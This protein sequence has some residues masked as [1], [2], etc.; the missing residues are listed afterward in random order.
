MKNLL[1]A[2]LLVLSGAACSRVPAGHVGVIVHTMGSSKGVDSEVV[3]IGYY[4][5]AP[6][7]N[8]YLFP[9]FMQNT[10]WTKSSTE[11]NSSN[12]ESFT[13]QTK[14][15]LDVNA[16]IGISYEIDPTKVSIIFQKYRSG[17]E[18]ITHTFLRNMIRDA[19]NKVASNMSVEE[20]YGSGKTKLINDVQTMVDNETTKL[21]I[22]I[23]KLYLTGSMRLPESIAKALNAKIA[24]TQ[25]AM[26]VQN[27]VAKAKAQADIAVAIA[28][29]EAKANRVKAASIT[30]QLIRYEEVLKWNGVRSQVMGSGSMINLTK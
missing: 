10:I 15:G 12:D 29:G 2:V 18:E 21:G 13:F 23:D 1:L 24:A 28:E 3:G 26:Q 7:T 19:L 4:F 20:V 30:D 14:E 9:T 6:T 25:E 11:G 17:I 16:D 22:K 8:L 27:E 5:L